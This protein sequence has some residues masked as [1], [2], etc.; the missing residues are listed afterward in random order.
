MMSPWWFQSR[1]NLRRCRTLQVR[2][3]VLYCEEDYN[4][5]VKDRKDSDV[6]DVFNTNQ[7]LFPGERVSEDESSGFSNPERSG[8]DGPESEEREIRHGLK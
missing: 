3:T 1:L 2:K 4:Y 8:E 5:F 6:V 7:N